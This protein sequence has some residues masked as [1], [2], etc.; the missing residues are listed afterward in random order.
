MFL[1]SFLLVFFFTIL[2]SLNIDCYEDININ[3]TNNLEL[4]SININSNEIKF[5]NIN[6]Q[7]ISININQ[8]NQILNQ[9]KNII[10]NIHLN[11]KIKDV[12][13]SSYSSQINCYFM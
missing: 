2:R 3:S 9:L 1:W 10:N 6:I 13:L 7:L 12:K 5:A 8:N 11:L 4:T